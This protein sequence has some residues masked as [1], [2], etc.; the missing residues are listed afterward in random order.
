MDKAKSLAVIKYQPKKDI[1]LKE[2]H[3]DRVEIL[4]E[5]SSSYATVKKWAAGFKQNRNSTDHLQSGRLKTSTTNEQINT[6]H[7]MV[8]ADNHLTF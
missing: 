6:I 7:Y 8:F 1:T 4:T 5:N 2:I 3:E